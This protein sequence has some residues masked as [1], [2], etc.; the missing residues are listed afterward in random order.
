MIT[1]QQAILIGAIMPLVAMPISLLPK[2]SDLARAAKSGKL[3]FTK[4][5][6]K[7]E[8]VCILYNKGN[9]YGLLMDV[10]SPQ[11]VDDITLYENRLENFDLNGRYNSEFETDMDLEVIEAFD[12]PTLFHHYRGINYAYGNK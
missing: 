12:M 11:Q 2:L 1:K 5:G 10:V 4:D 7:A 3:I 8:F 6:R 9:P